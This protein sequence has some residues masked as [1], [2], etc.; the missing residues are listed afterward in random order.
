MQTLN[1]QLDGPPI[2]TNKQDSNVQSLQQNQNGNIPLALQ[3]WKWYWTSLNQV[4]TA[5]PKHNWTEKQATGWP[6]QI[7]SL[8]VNYIWDNRNFKKDTKT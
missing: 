7:K 5:Y 8:I 2:K 1:N 6:K 3:S 4:V